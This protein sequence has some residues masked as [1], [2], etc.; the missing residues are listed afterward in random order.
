MPIIRGA[1]IRKGQDIWWIEGV[2]IKVGIAKIINEAEQTIKIETN[3][4]DKVINPKDMLIFTSPT[5]KGA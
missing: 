2:N 5:Q 3:E 1:C 4:G